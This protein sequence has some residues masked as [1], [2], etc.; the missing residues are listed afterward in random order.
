MVKAI[1]EGLMERKLDRDKRADEES[2]KAVKR[3]T[4]E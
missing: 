1:E 4:I 3:W 2:K